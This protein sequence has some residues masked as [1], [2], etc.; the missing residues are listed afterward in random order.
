MESAL[1]LTVL[2]DRSSGDSRFVVLVAGAI[3]VDEAGAVGT[4]LAVA[5]TLT[6]M[7]LLIGGWMTGAWRS[8][9]IEGRSGP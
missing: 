8:S 2:T 6:G 9:R 7:F 5:I 4:E 1:V 3:V